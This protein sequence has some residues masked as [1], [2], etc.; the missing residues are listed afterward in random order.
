MRLKEVH[1][2]RYGPLEPIEW[3]FDEGIN[4][5]YGPNQ[6]G[7]TLLVEALL[8]FFTGKEDA[9]PESIKRVAE[10]PDGYLVVENSRKEAKVT[11]DDPLCEKLN[12][13]FQELINTFVVRNTD[14]QIQK[15]ASFYGNITDRITGLWTNS[16]K[17]ID[18]KLR[19]LGRLTKKNLD[20]SNKSRYHN[21]EDQKKKQNN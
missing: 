19:D 16:I 9:L 15:E 17:A 21:A 1:I 3:E 12:I 6:S 5:I 4:P 2:R 7:K 8:D 13:R 14:L 10:H 18:S 11:L 20:L